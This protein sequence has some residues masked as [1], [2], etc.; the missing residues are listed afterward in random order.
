MEG[1]QNRISMLTRS[2]NFVFRRVA[3]IPEFTIVLPTTTHYTLED[4]AV[5]SRCQGK[6]GTPRGLDRRSSGK[7]NH[8]SG[9][10]AAHAQKIDHFPSPWTND[11]GHGRLSRDDFDGLLCRGNWLD[12]AA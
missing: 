11:A 5:K 2:M 4:R 1:A 7:Q 9:A 6:P 3:P 10:L 8:C 12:R